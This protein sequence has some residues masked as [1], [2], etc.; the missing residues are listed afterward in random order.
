MYK[1]LGALSS[2]AG[3]AVAAILAN[4]NDSRKKTVLE[5]ESAENPSH[6][7]HRPKF[8]VVPGSTPDAWQMAKTKAKGLAGVRMIE[9]GSPGCVLGVAVNGKVAYT[10]GKYLL[11]WLR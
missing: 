11:G 6:L 3:V 2:G 10:V 8:G 9:A 5:A 4:N 1:C 7:V